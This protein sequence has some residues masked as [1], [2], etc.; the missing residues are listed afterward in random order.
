MGRTATNTSSA[1]KRPSPHTSGHSSG[2]RGRASADSKRGAHPGAGSSAPRDIICLD[3]ED[4]GEQNEGKGVAGTK[5]ETETDTPLPAGPTAAD[6]AG[7]AETD[8]GDTPGSPSIGGESAHGGS[9]QSTGGN[10][11]SSKRGGFFLESFA[12]TKGNSSGGSSRAST[13]AP[14]APTRPKPSSSAPAVAA[15]KRKAPAVPRARPPPLPPKPPSPMK[16][17]GAEGEQGSN[18]ATEVNGDA[19]VC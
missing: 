11:A 15:S 9:G 3:G 2:V 12:Y 5:G 4:G 17:E 13:A 6:T 8:A 16:E 7:P 14:R 19:K 10:G 1:Q 18:V